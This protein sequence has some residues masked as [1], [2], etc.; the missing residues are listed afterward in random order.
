MKGD[1]R[2]FV[3]IDKLEFRF[4]LGWGFWAWESMVD[5]NE[6]VLQGSQRTVQGWTGFVQHGIISLQ[7][8]V[9]DCLYCEQCCLHFE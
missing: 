8:V 2:V 1:A 7:V 5:A 9:R 3:R 4:H 6:A